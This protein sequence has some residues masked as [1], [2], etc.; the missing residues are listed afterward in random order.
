MPTPPETEPDR[1]LRLQGASNFRDLGGYRS[2]DGR[3]LRWRQLFR[4]EHLADLTP[5]DH[6]TLA[7]LGLRRTLDFRGAAER[8]AQAYTLPG[9]AQHALSIEPTVVQ[10]MND[11]ASSGQSLNV[12]R[13]T[14]L[15]EELYRGLALNQ[16]P[17]YA[18]FFDHLLHSEGPL[19]FHCTAGKDRTG[20]AAA[21][22][23]LVLDVPRDVVLQ[24]YLLTN[25]VFQHQPAPQPGIPADAMQVLWRVQAGFLEA[26]LKTVEA[27]PGGMAAYLPQR[28]GLTPAAQQA[29]RQRYL[30][31]G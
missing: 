21:L 27:L 28:L 14:E 8:A 12:A 26:G 11:I 23:L 13:V 25:A 18:E 4:S 29:L 20:W 10:R 15:M 24:D 2:A 31:E 1:V 6:R 16:A 19:V 7:A 17:R 5:E 30:V 9:V 22:L 3:R